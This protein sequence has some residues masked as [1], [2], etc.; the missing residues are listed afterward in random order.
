MISDEEFALIKRQNERNAKYLHRMGRD[1]VRAHRHRTALLAEVERLRAD[2]E[3][4]RAERD[5]L[6]LDARGFVRWFNRHYTDPSRDPDHPWCAINNR[7]NAH[8]DTL[9]TFDSSVETKEE[10][11]GR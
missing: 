11:G 10:E 1:G 5:T 4:L 8:A 3:R 7:L 9:A 2:N 6:L